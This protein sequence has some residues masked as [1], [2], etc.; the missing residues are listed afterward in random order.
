MS[1]IEDL[2]FQDL[3]LEDLFI[4]NVYPD[5]PEIIKSSKAK[6]A[7]LY[8]GYYY[9]HLR[10]NKSSTVYKCREIIDKKECSGS[11]TLNDSS[12]NHISILLCYQL[13][14]MLKRLDLK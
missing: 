11:L 7:I 4:V 6:E 1:L 8:N 9:N 3:N 10:T 5:Q 12:P 14:V 13:S 2:K